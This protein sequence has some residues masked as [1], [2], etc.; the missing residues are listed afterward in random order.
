MNEGLCATLGALLY[1]SI[2]FRSRNDQ[3]QTIVD[4]D[5]VL[6]IITNISQL[7][8]TLNMNYGVSEKYFI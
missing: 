4:N 2:K 5:A 6:G 3:A 8:S 1:F 7:R